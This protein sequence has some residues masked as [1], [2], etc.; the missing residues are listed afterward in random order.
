MSSMSSTITIELVPLPPNQHTVLVTDTHG[1]SDNQTE[2][3][4]PPP[5]SHVPHDF[6]KGRSAA[7]IVTVAGVNFLNTLGSGI[8]TVALP[9]I[10]K[11]LHLSREILL[12]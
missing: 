11:D 10:A 9:Q 1:V 6:S 3:I 2:G 5:D 7:I 8:L 4:D 12:W